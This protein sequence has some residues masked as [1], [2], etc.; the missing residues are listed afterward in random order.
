MLPP[1]VVL[2][3]ARAKKP[4]P[5]TPA[6]LSGRRGGLLAEA[7]LAWPG[8][9]LDRQDERAGSPA[10]ELDQFFAI[11]RGFIDRAHHSQ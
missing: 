3:L 10:R 1:A 8:A 9:A 6:E 7:H 11:L 5:L 2:G 4:A